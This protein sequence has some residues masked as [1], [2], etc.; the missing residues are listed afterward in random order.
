M[1]KLSFIKAK[2]AKTQLRKKNVMLKMASF[3]TGDK[4]YKQQSNQEITK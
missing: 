2:N 1:E 4:I 3:A